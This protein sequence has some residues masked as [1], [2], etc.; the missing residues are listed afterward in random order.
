ME[1]HGTDVPQDA[2]KLFFFRQLPALFQV[3][4][5]LIHLDRYDDIRDKLHHELHRQIKD[6][7]SGQH[8]EDDLEQSLD[9]SCAQRLRT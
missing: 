9:Q 6:K 5:F 8:D 3:G 1:A 2:V 7:V 4:K